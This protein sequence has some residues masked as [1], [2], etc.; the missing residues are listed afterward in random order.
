VKR[1]QVGLEKSSSIGDAIDGNRESTVALLVGY[2]VDVNAKTRSGQTPLALA[3]AKGYSKII[4]TLEK[5]G[6]K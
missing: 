5:A 4:E 2:K 6:A 1:W 3:R